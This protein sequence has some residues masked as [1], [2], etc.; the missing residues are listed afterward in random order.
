MALNEKDLLAIKDLVEFSNENLKQEIVRELT[1][2]KSEMSAIFDEK[3]E[4]RLEETKL[5]I[6]DV[7]HREVSSISDVNRRYTEQL[8]N[9]EERITKIETKTGLTA[10]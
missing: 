8:D 2:T 4:K 6:M 5:E 9:H 10:A 1:D 3:L 7:I